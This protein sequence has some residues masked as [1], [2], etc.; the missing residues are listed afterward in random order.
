[1]KNIILDLEM[2][3]VSM[4]PEFTEQRRICKTEIMEI[5]AVALDEKGKEVSRFMTYV[6]PAFNAVIEENYTKLTGITTE[7][8]ADAP[9]FAEG[10]RQFSDWCKSL[11]EEIHIYAWSDCDLVQVTREMEQK[12]YKK[13]PFEKALLKNW[14]DFQ[15]IFEKKIGFDRA[16]ALSDALNY[17]GF[18]FEGRQ[19]DALFDAINTAELFRICND[20]KLFNDYLKVVKEAMEDTPI[21]SSMGDL[22]SGLNIQISS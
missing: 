21:G 5:G 3:A 22:L 8:V 9:G 18:D 6:K 1:M 20:E 10:F 14:H 11:D 13:S 17:A 4:Q 12:K 7:M 19:H 16:I 15:K 2:N